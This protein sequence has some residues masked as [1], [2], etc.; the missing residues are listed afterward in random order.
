MLEGFVVEELLAMDPPLVAGIPIG[1]SMTNERAA[2]APLAQ[3]AV[4]RI[5]DDRVGR[6]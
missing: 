6:A 1:I 2:P 3:R 4:D 5:E